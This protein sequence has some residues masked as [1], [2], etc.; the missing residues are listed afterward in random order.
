VSSAY[1]PLVPADQVPTL[2][3]AGETIKFTRSFSSFIPP[4]WSYT[5]FLN[6]PSATFSK[7]A[8]AAPDNSGFAIELTPGECANLPAGLYR[9]IERVSNSQTGEV[10]TVG[11]GVVQIELDLATAPAGACLS[12]WEKQLAM[13]EAVL[14]GRI[15]ADVQSYQIAS[16][17]VV[18]IPIKELYALRAIAAQNVWKAA[19]PGCL[20]E[21]VYIHFAPEPGTT[22][23]PP[24]WEG[25]L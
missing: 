3:T 5:L 24:T 6:G 15:T 16:R 1:N 18:K 14:T 22:A 10:Y 19:N 23:Y 4:D 20:S 2:F 7:A 9:Y 8:T 12:F 17:A 21:S 13:I 11:E 25:S